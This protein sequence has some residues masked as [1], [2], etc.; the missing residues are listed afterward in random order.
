MLDAETQRTLLDLFG[1]ENRALLMYVRDAFPWTT[2]RGSG[3]LAIL[4]D[5]IAGQTQALADF[6]KFL[7]RHRLPLP[8]GN[9]YPAQFTTL[10]FVTLESLAPRLVEAERRA[11]ARAEADLE[12]LHDSGARAAVEKLLAAKRRHLPVLEGLSVPAEQ[13]AAAG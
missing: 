10:N 2:A 7:T 11:I 4:R 8:P 9:A 6:G 3:A 12:H 13:V 5:V 1:R